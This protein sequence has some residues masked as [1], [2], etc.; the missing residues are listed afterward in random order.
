MLYSFKFIVSVTHTPLSGHD[1]TCD[2]CQRGL[3]QM[4]NNEEVN[5]VSRNGGYAEYCTLR[6]EAVVPLPGNMD[7]SEMAP[8]LCA[9][10]TVFNGIRQMNI[11]QGGTVAIVGLG[12]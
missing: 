12:G 8:L 1:G 5:G 6:E 9:G 11:R 2:T 7:K 3:F 10:V 4:C